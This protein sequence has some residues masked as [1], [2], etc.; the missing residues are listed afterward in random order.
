MAAY[1]RAQAQRTSHL[2]APDALRQGLD[3]SPSRVRS[4]PPGQ[5]R[6]A[7]LVALRQAFALQ[8]QGE[9]GLSTSD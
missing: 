7:G 6:D 1:W 4:R 8:T 2:P 5:G 3:A 9:A